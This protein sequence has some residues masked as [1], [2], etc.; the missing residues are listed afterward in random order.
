MLETAQGTLSTL[1]RAFVT[2][3]QTRA[4]E[5][6]LESQTGLPSSN[7]TPSYPKSKPTTSSSQRNSQQPSSTAWLSYPTAQTARASSGPATPPSNSTSICSHLAPITTTGPINTHP[8]QATTSTPTSTPSP[9]TTTS[10]PHQNNAYPIPC[11]QAITG[12]K[13]A[14]AWAATRNLPLEVLAQAAEIPTDRF[15][16]SWSS[17]PAPARS[18]S[19]VANASAPAAPALTHP[20]STCHKPS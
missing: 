18:T 19:S 10:I 15:A 11:H 13:A 14:N 9:Q 16:H 4:C 5:H 20:A 7:S 3:F 2:F 1:H 6:R 8:Y 17:H 12:W